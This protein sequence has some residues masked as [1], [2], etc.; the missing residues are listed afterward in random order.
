LVV[1]AVDSAL[2]GIV[3]RACSEMR[4][5]PSSADPDADG[6]REIAGAINV[7]FSGSG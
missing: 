7:R 2:S 4:G 1:A 3:E 5:L 6:A